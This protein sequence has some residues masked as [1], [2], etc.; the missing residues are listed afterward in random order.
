LV[1]RREGA[2]AA[3]I[4]S[5]LG[6]RFGADPDLVRLGLVVG[7]VLTG[8]VLAVAY[9]VAWLL[10]PEVYPDGS[11]DVLWSRAVQDRRG[12]LLVGALAPLLA[13][14]LLLAGELRTHV[15]ASAAWVVMAGVD[16]LILVWRNAPAEELVILRRAGGLAAS[17]GSRRSG[18]VLVLRSLVGAVLVAGGVAYTSFGPG[19]LTRPLVGG[20]L[21][22]AALVVVFGPWW[23][24]IGHDLLVE[25][26]A[27]VRAEERA[28][29]AARVHDSV[30]QTLA[31]I[32]RHA[33]QPQRVVALARAQ[34]RELRTWLFEGP[35]PGGV[36]A[37]ATTLAGGIRWIQEEV[38]AAHD[39]AVEAVVVGDCELDEDLEALLGAAREATVNS[40]KWSGAPVVSVYAEVEPTRVSLYVRDR[41]RGF[42]PGGIAPDRRGV[43]SSI[44]GR[45]ARHGGQ[46]WVRSAPGEGTEVALVLPRRAGCTVG[47]EAG[48]EPGGG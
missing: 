18:R 16:G 41:G 37:A 27:R 7:T 40:A 47:R 25:R 8:G 39:V 14:A 23:L 31:L 9:V 44:R 24:R 21:V 5:G 28:E 38:E 48:T 34:E 15:L 36:K 32:Q 10:L 35:A 46:A 2:L 33:G 17:V 20:M 22:L 12:L 11:T 13:A 1:R 45:M 30:L 19:S 43:T 3:G 4:G 26:Q 6:A 42:D 29:M